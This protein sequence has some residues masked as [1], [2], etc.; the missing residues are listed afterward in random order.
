VRK[1]KIYRKLQ[2]FLI[3]GLLL[4]GAIDTL[5]V[6]QEGKADAP[7]TETAKAKIVQAKMDPQLETLLR[8]V[9]AYLSGL[10]SFEVEV[11][12]HVQV[13]RGD[14]Q[15]D[16][17]E[18]GV[19]SVA[20]PN[21][22]AFVSKKGLFSPTVICDGAFTTTY[23]PPNHQYLNRPAPKKL[24]ELFTFGVEAGS[25]LRSALPIAQALTA[26]KP[27]N[28]LVKGI[29]KGE[30]LGQETLRD[31]PCHHFKLSQRAI[32]WEFWVSDGA[33]PIIHKIQP[34]LTRMLAQTRRTMGDAEKEQVVQSWEL[35]N[36]QENVDIPAG[37]FR[38]TVP[39]GAK[40]VDKFTRVGAAGHPLVGTQ[41]PDFKM[42][43]LEG[44]Q[45]DFLRLKGKK[46]IIL[47][48]W[49]TWCKPC[50]NAMPIIDD[51][52]RQFQD[53]GVALYT[54][55]AS[56]PPE[57]IRQ[58]MQEAQIKAAV[59]LNKDHSVFRDYGVEGIPHTVIIG[60]DGIIRRVHVGLSKDLREKLFKDL[61]EIVGLKGTYDLRCSS[62][63]FRPNPIQA[64]VPI[65]FSCLLENLGDAKVSRYTYSL[66]L[67]VDDQI[68]FWGPGAVDILPGRQN[69][70]SVDKDVWHFRMIKPGT[71][72][73]KV[74][75]DADHR[76]TEV[77]ES[78][79]VFQGEFKVSSSEARK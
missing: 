11:Q 37:R 44:G 34:D 61:A 17:R 29:E 68:V 22:I 73:Y 77:D 1:E 13:H 63:T 62:A 71:Y 38:F 41:A 48:F 26:N 64:G 52:A 30:Y 79:N 74:I 67:V 43:L 20:K 72:K 50:R 66:Q 59:A 47:D 40:A 19:F 70:F 49:A 39:A 28:V 31:T 78:N 7:S 3:A 24:D 54:V 4:G 46:V 18:F 15:Q 36:W 9:D 65:T 75:L 45:V 27:Y 10:R 12:L 16:F 58:F 25:S 57:K 69:V 53:R 42:D 23:A 5:S 33:K 60:K 56:D 21:R 35:I 51:V 55:N 2:L 8:K 32:D 14:I 76:V 6:A